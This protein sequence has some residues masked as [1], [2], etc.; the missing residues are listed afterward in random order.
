MNS[1]PGIKLLF[2][3]LVL[4]AACNV[5][6]A[7]QPVKIHFVRDRVSGHEVLKAQTDFEC[8][9]AALRRVLFSF[10]LYA[11]LHPWI[12]ETTTVSPPVNGTSEVL[13][14]F[15]FPW[16]V[17]ERWSRIEVHMRNQ[18]SIVW[19]QIEGTMNANE[20]QLRFDVNGQSTH[21]D[22]SATISIG[23][24]DAWTRGFKKQ[25]VAEFIDAAHTLAAATD[26][27]DLIFADLS[28]Q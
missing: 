20:G 2:T 25:F 11:N 19:R 15:K 24:P 3:A 21:V 5:A 26:T 13:I 23:L 4:L 27:T 1:Y 14:R 28:P 12:T 18:D 10:H 7:E 22:Y 16:P 17:G 9:G 8:H 6:L